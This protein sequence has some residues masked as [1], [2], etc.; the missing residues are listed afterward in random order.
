MQATQ[1][2]HLEEL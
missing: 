1:A 2:G